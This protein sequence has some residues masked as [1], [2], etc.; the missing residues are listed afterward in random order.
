[1]SHRK[2][3]Q[4]YLKDDDFPPDPVFFFFFPQSSWLSIQKVYSELFE[5]LIIKITLTL[6]GNNKNKTAKFN[7]IILNIT[8]LLPV[9]GMNFY[10]FSW[11]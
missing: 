9:L 2:P 8:L 7:L 3:P 5:I 6:T 11:K 1:M 4:F 10:T